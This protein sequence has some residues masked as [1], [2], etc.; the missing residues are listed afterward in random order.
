MAIVPPRHPVDSSTVPA[1]RCSA[2]QHVGVAMRTSR[3]DASTRRAYRETDYRVATEPPFVLRIGAFSP[4]LAALHREYAVTASAFITAC[5]PHSMSLDVTENARR[6][7]ELAATLADLGLRRIDGVGRHPSN[8]WPGEP[9]YL[10]LGL[11]RES[12]CALG[13]QF[14]QNAIVW[15]GADAVPELILLR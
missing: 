2:A 5:N 12:A 8:G 14:E 6:Q 7:T 15:C 4:E 13:Q 1:C 10:V 9:S 3:I 11:A